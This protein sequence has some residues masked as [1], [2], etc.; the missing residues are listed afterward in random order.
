MFMGRGGRESDR[1][2][3]DIIE[4]ILPFLQV[5]IVLSDRGQKVEHK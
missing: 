4:K 5:L 3:V 2:S 1:L